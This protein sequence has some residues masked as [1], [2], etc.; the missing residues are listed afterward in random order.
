ML[1]KEKII[2]TLNSLSKKIDKIK[3]DDSIIEK[4][5]IENQWFIPQFTIES[6][7]YWA[8]KLT[9]EQLLYF[10]KSYNFIENS[11]N[12]GLV[13][14][15]NIPLAGFHDLLCILLSGNN[16][17]VK[18]SSSNSVL[19]NFLINSLIEIEPEFENKIVITEKLKN[20]DAYIATG[21]NNTARYFNYYF[22]NKPSIIRHNRSSIAVITGKE[23]DEELQNLAKDIF[24][25]FGLGCR[26]VS[27]IFVPKNYDFSIFYKNLENFRFVENH[28]KYINNYTYHKAIF[29][30]NNTKH[31]DNGFLILKEDDNLHS[32]LSTLFY[33]FYNDMSEVENYILKTENNIQ[34]VVTSTKLTIKT[35]PFGKSQEPELYDY[36]DNANTLKFLCNF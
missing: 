31:F 4:V 26:N 12:I 15:G 7:K 29:L 27:K 18:I 23:S 24:I 36:A 16:A 21:T 2:E 17:L 33:S 30:M 32:P 9:T 10:S 6:L 13:T 1:K 11:K 22:R 8:K 34:I 25:Y 14:A 35:V 19:M 28:N 5:R 3:I 20:C